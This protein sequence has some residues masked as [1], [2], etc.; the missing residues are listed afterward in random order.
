MHYYVCVCLIESRSL[1][2]LWHTP[3]SQIYSAM[4]TSV[5]GSCTRGLMCRSLTVS[6]FWG[7][8]T[9]CRVQLFHCNRNH[10]MVLPRWMH[11]MYCLWWC[12]MTCSVQYV[13]V[14]IDVWCIVCINIKGKKKVKEHL[15]VNGFPSH[16]YGS[17]LAIWDHTVL[18]ATRHKWTCPALTPSSKLV[19][20]LPTPE[21]WKAELT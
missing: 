19:L 13:M 2:T 6:G 12:V 1:R 7:R 8:I 15:A 21:G 14:M 18:P 16:I 11:S 3:A 4:V 20:D 5:W 10:C 9:D 17:S